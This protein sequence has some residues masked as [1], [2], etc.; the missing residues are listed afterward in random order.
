M[1]PPLNYKEVQVG[2]MLASWR[3]SV[4]IIAFVYIDPKDNTVFSTAVDSR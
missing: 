4:P 1:S 2:N 3:P